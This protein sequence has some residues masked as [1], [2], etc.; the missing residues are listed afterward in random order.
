MKNLIII[1]LAIIAI[2][3]W[4]TLDACME[5]GASV[6]VLLKQSKERE[7]TCA[8]ALRQKPRLCTKRHKVCLVMKGEIP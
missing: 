1:I 5:H 4:L 6:D 2:V 8:E 3:E 7:A